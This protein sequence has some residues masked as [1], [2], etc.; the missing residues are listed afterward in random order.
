MPWQIDSAAS[1]Y[2]AC[3]QYMIDRCDIIREIQYHII[4]T[5][6]NDKYYEIGSLK[7]AKCFWHAHQTIVS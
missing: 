3:S 2:A 1:H 5:H 7:G 6:F 4:W